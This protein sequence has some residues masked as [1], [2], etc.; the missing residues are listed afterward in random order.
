MVEGRG[1][2]LGLPVRQLY[3][4]RAGMPALAPSERSRLL[5]EEVNEVLRLAGGMPREDI[6]AL[7]ASPG[8]PPENYA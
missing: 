4:F 5:G 7:V 6:G 8:V 3:D 2:G 1:L